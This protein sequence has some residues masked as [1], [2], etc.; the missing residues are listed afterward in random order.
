M[1]ILITLREYNGFAA[2]E[3]QVRD[4]ILRNSKEVINISI[5]ELA[6]KT[7]TSPAT[8]VRLCK[9]LEVGGFGKLK[10]QLASEI[11]AFENIHLDVLDTTTISKDDNIQQI[12]DRITTISI[13]TIEETRILLNE[14]K[15]LAAAK[16]IMK[17]SVIDFFGL[18]ASNTVAFDAAY[19]FMRI[20]K[21]VSCFQL[22]D[23]QL[24]QS[25]NAERDHIAILFSYSGETK[26]II[27]IA[28]NLQKNAVT[29]IAITCSTKSKI[30]EYCDYSLF[31]SS[32]ESIFRSGAMS[33]RTSQLYIV[34][35]LY[36]ICTS[37]DYDKAISNVNRTRI[38]PK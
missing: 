12:I 11:K 20:G 4:Y 18:G 34:D 27:E 13:Q 2:A 22:S 6:E 26:E 33:S 8:I 38:I 28:K 29:T 7:Y 16:E 1:S 9:K 32:K 5:H 21:N 3:S 23:R 14:E 37:L 31:V 35:I 36:S 19:K 15:L 25:I 30:D 17:A 24:V 10:V